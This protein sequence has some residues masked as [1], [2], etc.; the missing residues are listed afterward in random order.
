MSM[1]GVILFLLVG[2]VAGWLGG[3]ALG[4][5]SGGVIAN[6]VIG[7]IGAVL[8]GFLFSRLGIPMMGLPPLLYRLVAAVV[9]S[10]ILLI[11]LRFVR[12]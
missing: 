5:E 2:L 9:G 10:V 8:G 12:R 7:V 3:K 1:N 6:L 11:L 4:A